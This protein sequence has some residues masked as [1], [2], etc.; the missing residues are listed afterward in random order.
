MMNRIV[1]PR[2]P[3]IR[4]E[5][6]MW[7]SNRDL[8]S[9]YWIS[10]HI[11][12]LLPLVQRANDEPAIPSSTTPVNATSTNGPSSTTPV[13]ATSTNGPSSTTPVS[14]TSTDRLSSTTPVSASSTNGP[15]ST[16]PVNASS[17]NGIDIGAGKFI[18]TRIGAKQGRRTIQKEY[19]AV[20]LQNQG[21]ELEVRFLREK[22][23]HYHFPE[24]EDDAW[25]DKENVVRYLDTSLLAN[26][27]LN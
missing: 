13:S 3:T 27:V 6:I 1:R 21:N 15:S 12:P 5:A 9:E 2:A 20:V 17:T 7:T 14:A 25:I 11:V 8:E 16:T 19:G 23:G 22:D 18:L 26:R 24:I 10:N 4:H